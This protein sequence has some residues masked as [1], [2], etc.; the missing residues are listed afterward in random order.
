[1]FLKNHFWI[2]LQL[3]SINLPV[4]AASSHAVSSF[5]GRMLIKIAIDTFGNN[6][7]QKNGSS[8]P[9]R[10]LDDAPVFGTL[11][12]L[13]ARRGGVWVAERGRVAFVFLDVSPSARATA[14]L[15]SENC[16]NDFLKGGRKSD[17]VQALRSVSAGE[18]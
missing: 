1:L 3:T 6:S 7:Q 5:F 2:Y 13:G 17:D 8:S 11:E 14:A 16:R 10:S 15:R 18:H 9:A 4:N 12:L